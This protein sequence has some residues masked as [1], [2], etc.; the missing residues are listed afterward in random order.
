MNSGT[1]F[2]L[3]L[4]SYLDCWFLTIYIEIG[5]GRPSAGGPRMDHRAVTSSG[6]VKNIMPCFSPAT[7]SSEGT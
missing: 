3:V 1:V 4:V 5:P 6:I 7:L 2:N